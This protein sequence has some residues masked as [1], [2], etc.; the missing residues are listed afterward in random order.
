VQA[1][2]L[3]SAGLL[4]EKGADINTIY[5]HTFSRQSKE[6]A[7]LFG[8]VMSKIRYFLDD[9]M[10]LA[11]VRQKDIIECNATQ[12]DTE[13]FIDFLTGIDGVEVSVCMLEISPNKYKI[14]F[15]SKAVDV[16][17][18]ALT[19]GGGGH[20]LASGCQISGDYEDVVDRVR[21]AVSR[22]I[23]D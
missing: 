10:A 9:R 16:S 2:T 23:P 12:S 17:A 11:T 22:E 5:Y 14:S 6:R 21:F 18:I 20:V 7:L 13:G 19:F 4:K 3:R 1:E 15:R 8:K